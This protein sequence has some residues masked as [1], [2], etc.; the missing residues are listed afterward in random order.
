MIDEDIGA[1]VVGFDGLLTYSR[2][3]SAVCVCGVLW[4]LD[5]THANMER[6]KG[7]H[8]MVAVLYWW[9]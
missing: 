7:E 5:N 9:T 2:I 8:G 4:M 3:V 6:R 1:V